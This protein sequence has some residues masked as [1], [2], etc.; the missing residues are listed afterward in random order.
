MI[1]KYKVIDKEG[2]E[3]DGTIDAV[4]KDV[5]ITSLQNRGFVVIAVNSFDEKVPFLKRSISIFSPVKSKEVVI[6]SRQIATLFEAQVS[7]L[8]VFRLLS[9]E[10]DNPYLGEVLVEV[11]DDLQGG[12]S[13]SKALEKHPKVFSGFYTNMVRAGEESG[14]LDQVFAYLADYLDRN[15]EIT[16]KAKSALIY[17][18]F[19][20]VTF[21]VVMIL[22]FTT[23]IPKISAVLLEAGQDIPI[24]TKI[25]MGI[26]SILVNY[27]VFLLILLIV[28]GY[29]LFRYIKTET[30]KKYISS[31]ELSIPYVGDLYKKLY[32]SRISDNMNTM[33]I[34][35]ISMIKALEITSTVVD[36]ERYKEILE[37]AVEM[38]RS[39]STV[40]EALSG[41]DEIPGILVQMV[42]VGEE[43]GKLGEILE[44]LSK[45][46]SREVNTAVSTLVDL[47]EP[48]M[49]VLLGLGVGLILTSVLV[50]IYNISSAV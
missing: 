12:S 5:A 46:Y 25:V 48:V 14:K 20:I 16:S 30:G 32:L 35:G 39:G 43:T 3:K 8:R 38:V 2:A 47:I 19:I 50:P 9:A 11:A 45:F 17:P 21:V 34:S 28:G 4:S 40:S 49:I 23:V 26:S 22:M 41:Y 10:S 18:A 36:N 42:R 31:L 29:F 15:D 44:T 27:G 24:Y 7:A 37:R 33:L 6:L 1:F 13:I